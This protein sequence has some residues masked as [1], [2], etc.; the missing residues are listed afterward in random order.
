MLRL[1]KWVFYLVVLAAVLVVGGSFLLPAT[2]TVS[3]SIDIAAPPEKI[4][5]IVSDLRRFNEF[6]PWAELDPEAQYVFE[7]PEVGVGQIMKWTSE[8]LG[9]GSQTITELRPP[10]HVA[11]ALDFG[12]MGRSTAT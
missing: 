10:S 4:F 5:A 7:G 9:N 8:D 2:V 11:S 6:S 3:R 1:L 12:E